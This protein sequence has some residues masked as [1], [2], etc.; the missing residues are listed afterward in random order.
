MKNGAGAVEFSNL[1]KLMYLQTG[2]TKA[3]VLDY[4]R[5]ASRHILPH[6][7]DRPIT[8]K[9]FPDGVEGEYFYEKNAPSFTPKWVETFPI[10][11]RSGKS[12]INYILIN[13]LSTLLWSANMANL[14]IHTFLARAPRI[15]SPTMVVFDLDPGEG[16]DI[17][18]SCEVA[19]LVKELLGR[20][21]LTCLPKVSGSKGIH[22]HVPLNTPVTYAA[23]KPFAKA[24][25]Q[26]LESEHPDSIVSEMAKA[27]RRGKVFID[28]S[29]NSEHKSTVAVY[30]LRAQAERPFV[31]MPVGWGEIKRALK[32]A[33]PSMLF[34]EAEAALREMQRAG[35]IFAPVLTLKQKLPKAFLEFE[36]NP[37]SKSANSGSNGA[38][39][40]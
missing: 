14:E 6:L 36:K 28:W 34:F 30:S 37:A 9:R 7:K 26:L 2:F 15:D 19:F 29:Q 8:L 4:Y 18:K 27:K 33:E 24:V 3:Q 40:R 38:N 35:D 11:S 20:L 39:N 5:R 32:K 10:G 12:H 21:N 23:T 25:A 16:A 22:L 13:D 1:D 31:A 17:L